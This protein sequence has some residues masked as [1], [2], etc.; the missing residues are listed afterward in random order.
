M[1]M[2]KTV[3]SICKICDKPIFLNAISIKTKRKEINHYHYE[4]MI[5]GKKNATKGDGYARP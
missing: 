1:K 2:D 4:C 3:Y 5:G